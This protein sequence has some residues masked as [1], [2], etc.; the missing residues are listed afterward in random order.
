MI[1][2]DSIGDRVDEIRAAAEKSAGAADLLRDALARESAEFART[3]TAD[4]AYAARLDELLRRYEEQVPAALSSI[5]SVA[6]DAQTCAE[7]IGSDIGQF[8]RLRVRT[9]ELLEAKLGRDEEFSRA[10]A[11]HVAGVK[12]AEDAQRASQVESLYSFVADTLGAAK[13]DLIAAFDQLRDRA[14]EI[15][16]TR[17]QHAASQ[18]SVPRRA[19]DYASGAADVLR[20]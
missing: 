10:L 5:G 9:R 14:S 2:T 13:A 6:T 7:F 19:S 17:A 11:S 20:V 16:T 18:A 8:L 12:L 3:S 1:L 15:A 4:R